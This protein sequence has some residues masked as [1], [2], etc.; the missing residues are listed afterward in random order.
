M[1]TKPEILSEKTCF[2]EDSSV[3]NIIQNYDSDVAK[4]LIEMI[5]EQKVNQ[6][7]KLISFNPKVYGS[8]NLMA[9]GFFVVIDLIGLVALMSFYDS[10]AFSLNQFLFGGFWVILFTIVSRRKIAEKKV[11]LGRNLL[12]EL[13]MKFN[14]SLDK[15]NGC[16][17]ENIT[18]L[19]SLTKMLDKSG[20]LTI[21]DFTKINCSVDN[22]VNID[23][24]TN[25]NL[26]NLTEFV[27]SKVNLK[28]ETIK[29]HEIK[30]CLSLASYLISFLLDE[31]RKKN[32]I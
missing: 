32:E 21:V 15:D 30:E 3:K 17:S 8:L 25:K 24:E 5:F 19:L 27:R 4:A 16:N 29:F 10:E 11:I 12:D 28:D 2:V 14:V 9:F 20:L 1:E 26:S 7:E 6:F 23:E 31:K 18:N 22:Y 13:L